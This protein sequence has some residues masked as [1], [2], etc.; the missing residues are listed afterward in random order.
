M[1]RAT[2]CKFH[3]RTPDYLKFDDFWSFCPKRRNPK[4]RREI[5]RVRD[6]TID[7]R[8]RDWPSLKPEQWLIFSN[9][10]VLTVREILLTAGNTERAFFE[11]VCVPARALAR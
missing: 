1:Q 9:S 6:R 10:I 7:I 4:F 8:K 2:E 3:G 11:Q 5:A